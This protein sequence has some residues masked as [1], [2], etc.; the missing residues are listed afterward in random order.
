MGTGSGGPVAIDTLRGGNRFE[1]NRATLEV[2]FPMT[3]KGY[4]GQPGKGRKSIRTIAS[5]NPAR[6]AAEFAGLASKNPVSSIP[7]EGKGMIYRMRDGCIIIYRRMSSSKDKSPVVE[8]KI[9]GAHA[10]KSQKIHFIK[11]EG[12]NSGIR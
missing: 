7:I 11:R 3:E 12:G 10:P 2:A 6:T 1:D 5:N 8:L 9:K 4:F